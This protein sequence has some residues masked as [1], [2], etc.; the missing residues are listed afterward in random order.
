MTATAGCCP[1]LELRQYTLHPGQR[2]VLVDLFDREFVEPQEAAGMRIV[3]QFRDLDRPDHFVWIRGFRDMPA[4]AD[5]LA[6]FYGGPV[7]RQHRDTANATMIDSDDVLLLRPAEPGSG[8]ATPDTGRPPASG[9]E[10]PTSVVTATVYHLPAPATGTFARTFRDEAVPVLA[11]TGAPPRACLHSEPAENTFPALPV[12]TGV[13]VFV[14]LARFPSADHHRDH[15]DRLARSPEW[16]RLWPG[17]AATLTAVPEQL[18]LAPT[19]R[20][21]L[22]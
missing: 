18:R 3:G 19:T 11:A 8:F 10:P 15:L 6:A 1:V 21:A 7:W 16:R 12:R 20:S 17:L 5:A 14:W 13:N 9:G 2:D 4:R 22:R